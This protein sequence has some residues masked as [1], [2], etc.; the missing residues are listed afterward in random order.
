[1]LKGVNMLPIPQ[2]TVFLAFTLSCLIAL[3]TMTGYSVCTAASDIR[4]RG[5]TFTNPRQTMPMPES[6]INRPVEYENEMKGADLVLVMDQDIYFTFL[7]LIQKFGKDNKLKILVNEGTCGIAAGQ[8]A[9]KKIDMGGFCCPPGLED[10]LPGL[11][12]H[13]IGIV[14]KAFLV[15]PDNPVANVSTDQLRNIYRGKIFRW[16]EVNTQ[17]GRPGPDLAIKTIGRL[18][19]KKRPGHWLQLLS[20]EN[21]FSQRL[22]EVGSIPDMISQ[23]AA[24]RDAIGWEVLTMVEKNKNM[25]KVKP[26]AIDGYQP[27]DSKALA[28]LQYPFYRTYNLTTW[29]GTAAENKHARKLV[30][31]MIREFDKLNPDKFGFVSQARLKKAGW[32]F[33]ENELIGEPQTK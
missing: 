27:Y 24:S 31:F 26:I 5:E 2:K 32:I 11:K 18:H 29:E 10:R 7:P 25:G 15:H 4:F 6:W 9:E 33:T 23:V 8:L 22:M 1:M 30:D 17:A 19:C 21:K 3:L 20:H 28:M 13:T 16:S 12:F 14:A